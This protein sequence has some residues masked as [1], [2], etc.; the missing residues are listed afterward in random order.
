MI[1]YVLIASLMVVAIGL[2]IFVYSAVHAPEGVEDE[3]G[4]HYAA[5]R[6]TRH[7]GA[8]YSGPERRR[9]DRRGERRN[10]SSD[11]GYNGPRRRATDHGYGEHMGIPHL[12]G[13]A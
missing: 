10:S 1:T 3:A 12:G 5:A 7:E 8:A 13:V 11:Q 2:G 4:F 6:A 9:S